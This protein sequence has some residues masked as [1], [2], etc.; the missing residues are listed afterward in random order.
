MLK[1][2]IEEGYGQKE[3]YNCAEKIL[4]GANKAY[5]LGL[6]DHCCRLITGFCGGIY[7]NHLCGAVAGGVAVLS[8]LFSR[9]RSYEEAVLKEV[10]REFLMI[11]EDEMGSIICD[12]LMQDHRTPESGCHNVVAKSAEVLDR[13]IMDHIDQIEIRCNLN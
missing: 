8:M 13:V 12:T 6:D 3:R 7:I 1:E 11:Y 9:E 5:G 10:I 4:K 2:F